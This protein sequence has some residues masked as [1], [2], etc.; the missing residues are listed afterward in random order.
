MAEIYHRSIITGQG[1]PRRHSR[2]ETLGLASV[3][4]RQPLF[5]LKTPLAKARSSS[6][7]RSPTTPLT[8]RTSGHRRDRRGSGSSSSDEGSSSS[9]GRILPPS[10]RRLR[11][12][13]HR[14]FN[15]L[16]LDPSFLGISWAACT[17]RGWE[18]GSL[19]FKF[20]QL[21]PPI[22]EEVAMGRS[23]SC[24]ANFAWSNS[25]K[26]GVKFPHQLAISLEKVE[27][28]V[29][30]YNARSGAHQR[31]DFRH[32]MF[33]TYDK[34]IKRHEEHN[35]NNEYLVHD[36]LGRNNGEGSISSQKIELIPDGTSCLTR[37]LKTEDEERDDGLPS[38]NTAAWREISMHASS[39]DDFIDENLENRDIATSN[40]VLQEIPEISSDVALANRLPSASLLDSQPSTKQG[41]VLPRAQRKLKRYLIR[42]YRISLRFLSSSLRSAV[43][44]L[45]SL[46][47][48]LPYFVRGFFQRSWPP[49]IEGYH[50]SSSINTI[51]TAHDGFNRYSLARAGFDSQGRCADPSQPLPDLP[52]W[53]IE[54][55][56]G[57]GIRD[58]SL[59]RSALTHPTALPTEDRVYSYERLEYLGDAV[60]ELCTREM[61]MQRHPEA[62]EGHLTT[63]GQII[64]S[65]SMVNK[66]AE[67]I[68]LGKWVLINAYSLRDDGL[69]ASPHIL[70]DVFE[71][72]L[73][74]LYVDRGLDAARNFLTRVLSG[75]PSVQRGG[76]GDIIDFKGDL[77]RLS[78]QRKLPLPRY[79][80]VSAPKKQF[81]ETGHRKKYWT[82]QVEFNKQAV[83]AASSFE[84]TEAER[85]AAKGALVALGALPDIGEESSNED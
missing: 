53:R 71:A 12:K 76:S 35:R 15:H 57:C 8:T 84:R 25:I 27:K 65:G 80:V 2:G 82:V 77:L 69:A 78:H 75:C 31:I 33:K 10:T 46:Y 56:L 30:E 9:T 14:Q 7:S 48:T 59:Y 62:D 44:F 60:L 66:Y 39:G 67:W 4:R 28:Y 32:S 17:V 37:A 47:R 58:I 23:Q 16:E 36:E 54:Q 42:L 83:G 73:G 55:L 51:F 49:K 19:I 85:L 26:L 72:L 45:L 63:Q 13:P 43:R 81:K 40:Q 5:S 79:M 29:K 11:F 6:T 61:L 68:G 52:A 34:A 22:E 38:Q 50:V 64:V 21:D 70:G 41:F 1:L 20:D 24:L 18:D 74:A 3:T